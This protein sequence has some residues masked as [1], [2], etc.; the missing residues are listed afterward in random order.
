ARGDLAV[1]AAA[2]AVQEGART[3]SS[4][5]SAD[6][7]LAPEEQLV[8]AAKYAVLLVFSS[9]IS[10]FGRN[11]P[12]QQELLT[13]LADMLIDVYASE[14]PLLRAPQAVRVDSDRKS[15][16]VAV[17]QVSVAAA[18]MRLE[19]SG[20]QALAATLTD[21]A[22]ENALAALRGLLQAA[23]VNTVPLRRTVADAV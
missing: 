17:I 11:L 8:L 16:P 20:R 12:D 3:A 1:L 5:R 4:W 21:S 18:A 10:T 6:G 14:C 13:L 9:A 2:G 7:L 15:L 19:H 23:P 22:L